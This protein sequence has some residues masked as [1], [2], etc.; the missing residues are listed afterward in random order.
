MSIIWII[1][2]INFLQWIYI[3]ETNL[4]NYFI[5][6]ILKAK[7]GAITTHLMWNIF[8]Q[9]MEE[10]HVPWPAPGHATFNAAQDK[11]AF[12][13]Y[14]LTLLSHFQIFI[15]QCPQDLLHQAAVNQKI[16]LS[17]CST[18][19]LPWTSF[20]LDKCYNYIMVFVS[21]PIA[22]LLL[23]INHI[24]TLKNICNYNKQKYLNTNSLIS[25]E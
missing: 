2:I 4:L 19:I 6:N 11:I 8:Q 10:N 21:C 9:R 16:F 17:F 14:K 13:G 1:S 23:V 22:T 24:K 25:F 5:R 7:M 12:L 18:A 15:C 20:P 3:A